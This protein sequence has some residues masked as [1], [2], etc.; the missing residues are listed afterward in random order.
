MFE[1]KFARTLLSFLT[2]LSLMLSVGIQFEAVADTGEF[3]QAMA[4]VMKR[5]IAI[6]KA[7]YEDKMDGVQTEAKALV[8][9]LK[10]VDPGT[11]TGE[12]AA[13]YKMIPRKVSAAAAKLSV[14]KNL[15]EAREA[16]KE[17]SRP[18]AMWGGMSKPEGVYVMFCSMAKSSWLQNSAEIQNPFFGSQMPGCGEVISGGEGSAKAPEK[19][20]MKEMPMHSTPPKPETKKPTPRLAK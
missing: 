12:H 11:V 15:N 18:L 8:E 2:S 6:H 16:F 14:A 13:H 20:K 10:K 9:A 4:P 5:Y 3:D 1:K 19:K 7:L 17:V